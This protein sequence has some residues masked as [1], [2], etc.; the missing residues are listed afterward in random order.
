MNDISKVCAELRKV[1]TPDPLGSSQ[2]GLEVWPCE[3]EEEE[4]L[5][6][7]L[8]KRSVPMAHCVPGPHVPEEMLLWA[9][10]VWQGGR[11]EVGLLAPFPMLGPPRRF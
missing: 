3:A 2:L 1:V 7:W 8:H 9:Q 6:C 4:A 10:G 5:H 11:T